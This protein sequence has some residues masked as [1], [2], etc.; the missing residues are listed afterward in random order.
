MRH[1]DYIIAG[2]GCAGLSLAVHLIEKGLDKNK[3]ILLVDKDLKNKNDRTWC[4]WETKPGIFESIVLKQWKQLAVISEGFEKTASIAPYTYKMIRGIDFYSY[5]LEKIKKNPNFEWQSG[6]INDIISS[7]SGAEITVSGEKI[8]ATYLFSSILFEKP[9]LGKKHYYLLQHFKG[10]IIETEKAVFDPQIATLMDFRVPQQSDTAFVYVLPL[11]KHK[12]LIEYTIFSKQTIPDKEYDEILKDYIS[13]NLKIKNYKVSNQEFGII[14]MT[15]YSFPSQKG[16]VIYIGTAGG[17]TK[18][19]T[20]YTFQFI[21]RHINSITE[22]IEKT[23]NP[24]VKQEPGYK[25]FHFYDTILLH[26]LS[27]RRLRGKDIFVRLFKRNKI[28]AVLQFLENKTTILK[29]SRILMSLNKRV[30]TK[31]VLDHFR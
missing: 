23:G 18:P 13:K 9:P 15:N 21:Q 27:N 1:Y 7:E 2:T 3:K 19:S 22:A 11:T 29:E 14:P 25:R 5:A 26:I 8:S 12:A 31:A 28:A 4:F 17:Q 30:F 10:W 24:F 6:E 16:N 20:G